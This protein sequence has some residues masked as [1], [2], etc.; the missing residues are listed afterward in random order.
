MAHLSTSLPTSQKLISHTVFNNLKCT[1]VA[2]KC[3]HV[4]SICNWFYKK[5]YP[6]REKNSELKKCMFIYSCNSNVGPDKQALSI[7]FTT[8]LLPEM[9]QNLRK[10]IAT[11]WDFVQ[12]NNNDYNLQDNFPNLKILFKMDQIKNL[13]L[14][15]K[16]MTLFCDYFRN[17]TLI[18]FS[19][20]SE[21][22]P[23]KVPA[24]KTHT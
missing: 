11:A 10:C 16:S 24:N 3:S 4:I 5:S 13:I 6:V 1:E 18:S 12:V 21:Y 23:L 15:Q 22:I 9:Y 17:Q 19:A 7:I 2:V 20:G 8:A 14:K